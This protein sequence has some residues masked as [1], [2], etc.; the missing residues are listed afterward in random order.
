[1]GDIGQAVQIVIDKTVRPVQIG[2]AGPVA[3]LIVRV[4]GTGNGAA[5]QLVH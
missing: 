4:G 1:M 5:A 3:H 2:Q